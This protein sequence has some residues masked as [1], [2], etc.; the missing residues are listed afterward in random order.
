MESNTP[1]VSLLT[2]RL[3][4][5]E[6]QN[7]RM[8]QRLRLLVAAIVV[9]PAAGLLMGAAQRG[10]AKS[11][12]AEEFLL[13]EPNGKVRAALRMEE[14]GPSFTLFDK[15]DQGRLLLRLQDGNSASSFY[16]SYPSG[17]PAFGVVALPTHPTVGVWSETS[18]KRQLLVHMGKL[19]PDSPSLEVRDSN[20][21][22]VDSW[23]K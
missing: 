23:G 9:M 22:V 2:Q 14:S 10:P 8:Q 3:E 4:K 6:K 21:K 15:Q 16:V 1:V 13:Q 12:A 20:G 19:S 5:L 11:L 17:K 7:A 18:D